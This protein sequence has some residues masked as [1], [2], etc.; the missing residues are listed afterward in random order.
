M[1]FYERR[2]SVESRGIADRPDTRGTPATAERWSLGDAEVSVSRPAPEVIVYVFKGRM[3]PEFVEHIRAAA[4]P[5]VASGKRVD[6]FF[7]TEPMTGYHPEFRVQ[8][9]AWHEELEN[10]TRSSGVLVRS[11]VVKMA[12]AIANLATGGKMVS[13]SERRSFE[14][15]IREAC[16]KRR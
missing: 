6:L 7:D 3:V 8:M 12:I 15:A 13:Y 4:E 11:R 16:L 10:A 1:L 2:A 9:T 5:L 14:T